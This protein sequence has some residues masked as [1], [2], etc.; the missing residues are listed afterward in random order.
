M[1]EFI[2]SIDPAELRMFLA[3]P[4]GIRMPAAPPWL[5]VI[6]YSPLQREVVLFITPIF[7][8]TAMRSSQATSASAYMPLI[9]AVA[10]AYC[11]ERAC[12]Q[13]STTAHNPEASR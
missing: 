11:P 8:R 7:V 6:Y 2:A 4:A 12:L 9:L 5:Q 1:T 13:A 10:V 3:T